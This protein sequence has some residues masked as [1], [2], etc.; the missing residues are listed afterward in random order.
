MAVADRKKSLNMCRVPAAR[1]ER[2]AAVSSADPLPKASQ[3]YEA[4]ALQIWCEFNSW[5][6]CAVCKAAQPRELT[7]E[8]V[9]KILS[10]YV[11]K[12]L[13]IF[14]KNLRAPPRAELTAAELQGL[15]A[16]VAKALCCVEPDF[17]PEECSR[18]RFGR[19]NG[20]R[21][22]MALVTFSWP[23][24]SVEDQIAALDQAG[25]QMAEAA[26]EW[27][28]NHSGP[29]KN[30]SAYATFYKAHHEFLAK[31]P[32]AERCQRRRWLR[33]LEAEGLECALWPHLF[34]GADM[35]DL[36]PAAIPGQAGSQRRGGHLGA[37]GLR[38][39]GAH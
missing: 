39:R 37:A 25:R 7:V 4:A 12:S 26:L 21:V 2:L 11:P 14:C 8:G 3:S 35:L 18:D 33:F 36:A 1:L 19:G 5:A 27:L 34:L 9:Q 13:C 23:E 20:Y 28:L 30:E 38:R 15:P 17:G 24:S 10:P 22:H 16:A 6:I 32:Q 29:S 31:H